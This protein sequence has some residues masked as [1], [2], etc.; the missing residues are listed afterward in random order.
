MNNAV[1]HLE[2]PTAEF[3]PDTCCVLQILSVLIIN[4]HYN[5]RCFA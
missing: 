3:P 1:Y 5:Q 4:I 2:E